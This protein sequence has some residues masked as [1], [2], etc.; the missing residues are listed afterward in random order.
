[1]DYYNK[2]AK[3]ALLGRPL[4]RRKCNTNV[5]DDSLAKKEQNKSKRK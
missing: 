3:V 4:K 5:K 2:L 1:M